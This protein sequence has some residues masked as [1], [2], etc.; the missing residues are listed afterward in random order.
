MLK[1]LEAMFLQAVDYPVQAI[2]SQITE[3][4]DIMI[5]MSRQRDGSRKLMEIAELIGME[6]GEIQ[7]NVLYKEGSGGTGNTLVHD[8]KLMLAGYDPA[9]V[10]I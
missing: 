1:R 2:R 4:I 9:T 8:E 5:H 7:I 10:K 6:E 3:G